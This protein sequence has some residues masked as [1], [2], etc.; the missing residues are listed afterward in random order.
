MRSTDAPSFFES[1]DCDARDI[2]RRVC[3]RCVRA[4]RNVLALPQSQREGCLERPEL[5]YRKIP[6]I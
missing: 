5:A 6:N 4:S 2:H 1:Q 3:A